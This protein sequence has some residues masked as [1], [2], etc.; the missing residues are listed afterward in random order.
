MQRKFKLFNKIPPEIQCKIVQYLPT[1][2]VADYALVSKTCLSL[3]KPILDIRKSVHDFLHAVV[4][5]KYDTVEE[6]LEKDIS[7]LF[8]REEQI[9]DCSNRIF[10]KISGFEY[11]LWALDKYMWTTML[12]CL[13]KNEKGK[14]ALARLL[15]QYNELNAKG[16]TYR[17]NEQIITEKHF[18]FENTIIKTLQIQANFLNTPE[19]KDWNIIDKQWREDV[20]GAQKLLPMHV[21][22]EYCSN[23]PFYPLPIFSY[24]LQLST[25]F[26]NWIA[27]E[28]ENWFNGNSKL[29]ISF[30]VYKGGHLRA[31]GRN[32]SP[33]HDEPTFD[34][35][36]AIMV[37]YDKRIKQFI[38]LESHF[39]EQMAVNDLQPHRC[40]QC[41]SFQ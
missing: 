10:I 15:T 14:E 6:M 23:V 2:N 13:P 30:A 7:I 39:K 24:P 16:V 19:T 22:Y 20:G 35:L 28:L 41:N 36:D 12:D 26:Y 29:G 3:F 32:S 27:C 25:Q 34:D 38:N 18:D 17:L 11:A 1:S 31:S 21:V 33:G 8:A 37:L 5:S 4:C 40:F 9:T